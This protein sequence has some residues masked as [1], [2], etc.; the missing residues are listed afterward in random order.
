MKKYDNSLIEVWKWKEAVFYDIQGLS[1]K[2]LIEKITTDAEKL[3]K[4]NN[5]K[6]ELISNKDKIQ[7]VA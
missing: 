5:I 7:E 4:E 3:L 1:E 6:L 2:E